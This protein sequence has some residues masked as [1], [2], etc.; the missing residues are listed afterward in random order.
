MT[1]LRV[2]GNV[3]RR[4]GCLHPLV[5]SHRCVLPRWLL[6]RDVVV[7]FSSYPCPNV[8]LCHGISKMA[9]P[10][11]LPFF[12]HTRQG[13]PLSDRR[14]ALVHYC[15][16]HFL[17]VFR[18]AKMWM[19]ID[20]YYQR[21]RCSPY[22]SISR[23]WL[24]EVYSNIQI[25]IK[26]N[27]IKKSRRTKMVTNTAIVVH[28]TCIQCITRK[29]CCRKETARCHSCSFRVASKAS[30]QRIQTYRRKTEYNAKWPLGIIQCHVFWSQWK[31]GRYIQYNNV[32][33]ICYS[34][35]ANIIILY[36][37]VPIV[38]NC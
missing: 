18:F 11:C 27:L 37:L 28:D 22:D 8:F 3:L 34:N 29:P 14:F 13:A 4:L 5:D 20:P 33:L 21:R 15:S 12:K 25:K 6:L 19:K 38:T 31:G 36:Y 35:K 1:R 30:L 16:A 24:Y 32:G 23:F 7:P 26:S 10:G 2:A 17:V 9:K